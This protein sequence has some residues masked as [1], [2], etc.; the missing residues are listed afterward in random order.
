MP[1]M[2]LEIRDF[3]KYIKVEI[4]VKDMKDGHMI[5]T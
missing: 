4:Q 3:Y 2:I 1:D 5:I